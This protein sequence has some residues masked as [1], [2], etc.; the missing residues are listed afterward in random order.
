MS[1]NS[2]E[3][4]VTIGIAN[5]AEYLRSYNGALEVTNITGGLVTTQY[6]Y[7]SV[8]YPTT[9]QEIYSFYLGGSGGTLVSTVTVNYTDTTKNFILNVART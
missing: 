6:D 4:L 1:P 3:A 7:I 2:R 9:T 8:T 5:S